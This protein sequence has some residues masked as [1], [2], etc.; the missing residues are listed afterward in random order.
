MVDRK[1]VLV[2]MDGVGIKEDAFGNAVKNA[3]T[4]NL[5]NLINNYPYTLINAHGT[6]VGMTSDN[7]MGNSEVGH[8]TIGCGQIYSQ[9]AKLVDESIKS[10]EL[11][12]S[13][14]WQDL[15]NYCKDNGKMHFIG[16]LSDGNVH[17]HINHLLAMLEQ[18]KKDGI[19]E[20][21][22][23]VLLDGRDVEEKSALKYVNILENKIDELNDATYNA[24]IASGGGR[25]N[26]T[27]DRYEANWSMVEKGWH[28]HV[29]GGARKF[30][31]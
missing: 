11:F 26:I 24:F 12:K 19:K 18:A 20:V 1:I 16:V 2:I 5:D 14:T 28:T 3:K 4:P 15:V 7:D 31:S 9:G 25:M 10:K 29:L 30:K 13:K 22:I 27:M 17:S 8:N 21:R 6:Y 23:H